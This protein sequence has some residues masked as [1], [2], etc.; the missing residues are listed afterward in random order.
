MPTQIGCRGSSPFIGMA[1]LPQKIRRQARPAESDKCPK[2]LSPQGAS[3]SPDAPTDTLIGPL[4]KVGHG[5][6]AAFVTRQSPRTAM[7]AS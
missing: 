2:L 1:A 4:M 3:Q 6:R 5:M 7:S